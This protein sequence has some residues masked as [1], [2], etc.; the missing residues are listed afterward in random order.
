MHGYLASITGAPYRGRSTDVET[1]VNEMTGAAKATPLD[2]GNCTA[3]IFCTSKKR[4]TIN[5]STSG[6]PSE[7]DFFHPHQADSRLLPEA[8][9]FELALKN[10]ALV[11][12]IGATQKDASISSA[13]DTAKVNVAQAMLKWMGLV[14]PSATFD[15]SA[16]MDF[17]NAAYAD[18]GKKIVDD[19][20]A[21]MDRVLVTRGLLRE[22][23]GSAI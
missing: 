5:G 8:K 12:Y 18:E 14:S 10:L 13:M 17:V 19:I 20:S 16:G 2:A 15:Q 11:Q 23:T 7:G 1:I 4:Y 6:E 21:S 9:C 22:R 3:E